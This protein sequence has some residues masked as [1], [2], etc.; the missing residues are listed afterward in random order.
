M[1]WFWRGSTLEG[2]MCMHVDDDLIVASPWL[3]TE[4]LP[5]LRRRFP[6]GK[7]STDSFV[8]CGREYAREADGS[9][10][11]SQVGYAQGLE[12]VKLAPGRR[13]DREGTVT[14]QEKTEL[15]SLQQKLAWLA[16]CHALAGFL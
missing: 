11:I 5:K 13:L 10:V 14:T 7:W 16:R 1:F 3:E 9:V 6:Y 2:A 8:H 4:I 15:R 12:K